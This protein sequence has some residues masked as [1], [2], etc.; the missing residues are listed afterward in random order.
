V[1]V[2]LHEFLQRSAADKQLFF[3]PSNR[4]QVV[5]RFYQGIP[6]FQ[7]VIHFT[8]RIISNMPVKKSTG[9]SASIFFKIRKKMW[10]TRVKVH[11]RPEVQYGLHWASFTKLIITQ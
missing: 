7:N 11:L 6:Q 9:L 10:E 3:N 1:K 4:L 8:V 5:H 2:H